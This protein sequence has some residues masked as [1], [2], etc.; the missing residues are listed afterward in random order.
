MAWFKVDDRFYSHPKVLGVPMRSLGLW[1]LAGAW[2][3]DQL[4]DGFIP[5]TALPMLNGAKAA[6]AKPL[7]DAGLWVVVDGGWQFHDWHD[8]QPSRQ[9]VLDKRDREREKKQRWREKTRQDPA[10]GRLKSIAGGA[11]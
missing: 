6:D 9:E 7:V 1:V 10:T 5:K 2:S 3:A 4:T 8:M 11:Q